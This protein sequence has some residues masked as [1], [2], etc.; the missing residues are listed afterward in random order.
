MKG[1]IERGSSLTGENVKLDADLEVSGNVAYIYIYTDTPVLWG[2]K[3][4]S[5]VK[6][7]TINITDL[8]ISPNYIKISGFFGIGG[9]FHRDG[10]TFFPNLI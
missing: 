9:N 1:Y 4:A 8:T 7:L 3:D 5:F 10:I 6:Y 2:R